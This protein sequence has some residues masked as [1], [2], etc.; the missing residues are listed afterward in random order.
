MKAESLK[1]MLTK[2]SKCKTE[3]MV[4]EEYNHHL[5]V[6]CED[7]CI[8]IHTPRVRKTH[9]QYLKSIKTEYLI[10]GNED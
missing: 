7:C 3:I 9:W 2:C 6:L 5:K 4:R 8:D 1:K 10:S